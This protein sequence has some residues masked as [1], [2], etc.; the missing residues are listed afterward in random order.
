MS[1]LK[2]LTYWLIA[3]P[4]LITFFLQGQRNKDKIIKDLSRFEWVQDGAESNGML[5]M[6]LYKMLTCSVPFRSVYYMRVGHY[7]KLIR[8]LLPG[9]STCGI[10][11]TKTNK[12]GGGVYIQHGWGMVLDAESVGEN[13]WINQ[14]V[15]VGYRGNGHPR[16]GNNVRIGSGAVVLGGITIG[17]NVNIGANAIVVE[18][19]P[20]NCTVCSPKAK[21]VKYHTDPTMNASLC[22]NTIAGG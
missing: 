17:N 18:D 15:T 16:I 14:N 21:I 1:L 10:S 8:F 3:W 4:A 2:L 13:L 6:R 5:I 11:A 9:Q 20:D 12:V 7:A 19:V 22:S